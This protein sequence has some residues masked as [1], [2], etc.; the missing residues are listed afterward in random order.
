MKSMERGFTL[1]E[2]MIVVA[3]IGIL[4]AIAMPGYQRYL[5]MSADAACQEE[6][7]NISRAAAIAM[8]NNDASLLSTAALSA[9][10]TGILPANL[11]AANN[12][13]VQF[14]N[15]ARG[16]RVIVCDFTLGTCR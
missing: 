14:Q 13:N 6:A 3:I 15:A 4:A 2:L 5:Q 16:V 11:A 10:D 9:C 8:L 12:A 1:V 7:T